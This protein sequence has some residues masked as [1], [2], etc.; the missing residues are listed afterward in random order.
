MTKDVDA[1]KR[2]KQILRRVSQLAVVYGIMVK[3]H[4]WRGTSLNRH[5]LSYAVRSYFIDLDRF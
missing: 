2:H 1:Q 5:I 3:R 4:G